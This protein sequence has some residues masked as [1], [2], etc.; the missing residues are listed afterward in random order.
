VERGIVDWYA[1]RPKELGKQMGATQHDDANGRPDGARIYLPR[2]SVLRSAGL[3]NGDI[4]HRINGRRVA[5]I[6]EA[7]ATWVALRGEPS[8]K[9][10]LTRKTG[11]KL[12]FRYDVVK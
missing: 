12:T 3:R 8:V 7:L 4:V 9:L 6:P 5:S 1:T 10:E 2:C 11:E